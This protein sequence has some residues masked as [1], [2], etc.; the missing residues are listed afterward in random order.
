MW[1]I[2]QALGLPTTFVRYNPDVYKTHRDCV[3]RCAVITR[4]RTLLAWLD[5]LMA[6]PPKYSLQ[7][8]YLYYDGWESQ[9]KAGLEQVHHPIL[10]SS[11]PLQQEVLADDDPFWAELGL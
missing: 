3:G 9:E 2:R 4:E 8:M 10:V 6:Q 11:K 7:V 5:T 1:Q